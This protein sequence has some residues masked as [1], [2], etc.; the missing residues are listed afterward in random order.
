MTDRPRSVYIAYTGGTIGMAPS[1]KGYCPRAGFLKEQMD[2]FSVW[3][4]PDAPRWELHEFDPLLDS[5]NMTPR[6]WMRIGEDIVAHYD[7]FDGFIVLHGTDTMAYSAAALS[8]MLRDLDKP[9]LFTGSQVPLCELRTDAREN[10]VNSLI[11][12]A[13]CVVPEVC[14]YIGH[15]V[16]RG[17][18]TTKVSSQSYLAFDSPN[19][20]P[21]V[22]VGAELKV[23]ESRFL[24]RP[25]RP[26]DFRRMQGPRPRV[27][28]VRFFPGITPDMIEQFLAPPI[29]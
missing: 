18:R 20:P 16:L 25:E 21:L 17:N 5:S 26:L 29:Q 22:E 4:H 24:A 7:D 12:A 10:L 14:V 23:H 28:D 3:R 6:D 8:F 13:G 1:A 27:A 11:L 19:Y 2:Q 9:V 15:R